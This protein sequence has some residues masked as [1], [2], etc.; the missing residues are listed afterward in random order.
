[1]KN[2][3]DVKVIKADWPAKC[4]IMEIEKILTMYSLIYLQVTVISTTS[5]E[6]L[7]FNN[8]FT[9][10]IYPD[11]DECIRLEFKPQ[12]VMISS[13]GLQS[14]RDLNN[15]SVTINEKIYP[16]VVPSVKP[17]ELDVIGLVPP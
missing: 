1:M 5:F 8:S 14:I 10:Q 9:R 2:I 16:S 6:C 4:C 3:P 12:F 13:L 15:L 17:F 7:V 11:F